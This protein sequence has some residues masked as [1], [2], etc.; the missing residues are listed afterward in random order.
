M[1]EDQ[2]DM[3]LMILIPP[4]TFRDH[5]RDRHFR[6]KYGE[7]LHTYTRL[8]GQLGEKTFHPSAS[9]QK[10]YTSQTEH[11][12]TKSFHPTVSMQKITQEQLGAKTFHPSASMEK[13]YTPKTRHKDI[14]PISLY[15]ENLH[16]QNKAQR[17]FT[18][19]PLWRKSTHHK[20]DN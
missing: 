10:I 9:V 4:P 12:D 13:I 18:Q 17:H 15:G 5:Y 20:Q 1:K 8:T 19:Q 2:V 16:T 11:L 7:N 6:G 3:S 14:S